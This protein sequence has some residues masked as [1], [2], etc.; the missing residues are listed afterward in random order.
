MVVKSNLNITLLEEGQ[1]NSYITLNEA[2]LIL[3]CAA[4]LLLL[5]EGDSA[6]PGSPSNH[7]CYYLGTSCTGAW[8]TH[9]NELALY[10]G[11]SWLFISPESGMQAWSVQQTSVVF[12]INT[13]YGFVPSLS[14][15]ATEHG[16]GQLASVD[17]EQVYEK[18]IAFGTLPNA[19][20]KSVAHSISFDFTKGVEINGCAV[21]SSSFLIRT[22]P[23]VGTGTQISIQIDATNIVIATD[24][25]ATSFSAW[26]RLRY[27]K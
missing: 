3:D 25:D 26:L 19:T 21:S 2:I 22:I 15:S 16:L 27:F 20:S 13:T 14:F 8:A 1:A 17:A 9:D 6:P 4:G 11:S 24:F 23:S 5:T 18:R 10:T 7:G 12:F